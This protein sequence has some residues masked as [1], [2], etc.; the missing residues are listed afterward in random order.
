MIALL[1][2]A[3]G[4]VS[5]LPENPLQGSRL[6]TEKGCYSC[7]SI[8]GAGGRG[9]P[10]LGRGLMN[11][12]LLEIAGV[13]WNHSPRMEQAFAERR[14]VRPKLDAK[15]MASLLSFLYY[16]GSFDEPGDAA[17]GER[18]FRDKQCSHCHSIG[19][20][21][22]KIGPALDRFGSFV[23]PLFLTSAMWD[24]G[25]KMSATMKAL[26]V[27]RPRFEGRDIVDL[28]AYFRAA[29]DASQRLY[30]QP[31]NPRKG[32]E[33]FGAKKCTT[34]H[35]INGQGGKVGPDLGMQLKGSLMQIAGA[36]WNHGV[37]MWAEM[38]KRGVQ[39]PKLTP[40]E[41][42]NLVSY[43]YFLQFVDP[44]GD[45]VRG[46]AVYREAR[47][48]GCHEEGADG[49]RIAPSLVG[50]KEFKS[51]LEAVAAM[52]NHGAQMEKVM[53]KANVAWPMLKRGEMADLL[54]YLRK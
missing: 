16:L 23:S 10:D 31:G 3:S 42:G 15:E 5:L 32:E 36:M 54:A 19:G 4:L 20:S 53:A 35:A 25:P 41:T 43:L 47:C 1:L 37:P 21:G 39:V 7:H 38:S 44:P 13:M 11:R 52:W 49:K 33:L 26:G 2:A 24:A 12:P 17:S 29:G 14:V 50:E 30:A 18:I 51:S 8:Q 6:F 48:Q 28:L 40:E 34:C 45:A 27:S 9:G 22:G 46:Q